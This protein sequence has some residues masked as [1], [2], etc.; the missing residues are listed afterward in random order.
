M[1]VTGQITT[2]TRPELAFND[3]EAGVLLERA[4]CPALVAARSRRPR[5]LHRGVGLLP[6]G[7]DRRAADGCGRVPAR[8]VGRFDD[9]WAAG[10]HRS[11]HHC[12]AMGELLIAER[13]P[14]DACRVRR[15]LEQ[16][17]GL[18][19]QRLHAMA[20]LA[21]VEHAAEARAT[22]VQTSISL[23]VS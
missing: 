1:G 9:R 10:E 8:H 21:S 5:G 22:L 23:S 7:T 4:G 6:R 14:D 11:I 20:L 18:L 3:A 15:G 16:A 19:D 13:K 12:I 17:A 2:I